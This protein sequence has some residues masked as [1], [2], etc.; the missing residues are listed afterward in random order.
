MKN[1]SIQL[2]LDKLQLPWRLLL[3]WWRR[4]GLMGEKAWSNTIFIR[5]AL[6]VHKFSLREIIQC[7]EIVFKHWPCIEY[8]KIIVLPSIGKDLG[9]TFVSKLSVLSKKNAFLKYC[10]FQID[11]CLFQNYSKREREPSFRFLFRLNR[12]LSRLRLSCW[13][14]AYLSGSWQTR[15]VRSRLSDPA[16]SCKI[17]RECRLCLPH[18]WPIACLVIGLLWNMTCSEEWFHWDW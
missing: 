7:Y 15:T 5:C 9:Q 1:I 2:P 8:R 4:D 17:Y 13:Q 3:V 11:F 14:I 10:S 16:L 6:T 12:I 18:S